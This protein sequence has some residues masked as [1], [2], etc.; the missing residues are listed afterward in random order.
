MI[1]SANVFVV[2]FWY[3]ELLFVVNLFGKIKKKIEAKMLYIKIFGVHIYGYGRDD[4][5]PQ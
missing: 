4:K 5:I 1:G 3:D 2:A